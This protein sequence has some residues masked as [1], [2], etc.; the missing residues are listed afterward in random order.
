M[1][2][3]VS[4]LHIF[5]GNSSLS[6]GAKISEPFLFII[7]YLNLFSTSLSCTSLMEILHCPFEQ[8]FPSYFIL[9]QLKKTRKENKLSIEYE[10]LQNI[11][12]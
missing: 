3:H 9:F 7:I 1:K 5:N 6:I 10:P 8:K 2:I 4:V 12:F 11:K